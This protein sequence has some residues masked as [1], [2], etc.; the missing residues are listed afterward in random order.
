MRVLNLILG[1]LSFVLGTIGII[2]PVL[3]TV[4]FYLLAAFFFANSDEKFHS[5]LVNSKFYKENVAPF[6]SG[7]KIPLKIKIRAI[8]TVTIMIGIS[9]YLTANWPTIRVI[10]VTI[11]LVHFY[12][13]GYRK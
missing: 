10:L 2:L 8:V 9:F 1:I 12:I 3:P 7:A 11:W 13:I 6:G 5:R 4:P